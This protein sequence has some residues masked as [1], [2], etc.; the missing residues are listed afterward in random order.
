MIKI[1]Y[2]PPSIYGR[3]V[4]TVLAEKSLD[5]EIVPMSFKEKDHLKPEYLRL[6]PNGEIPTIDD[7]GRIIYESTAVIE[8]LDEEY[9]EP[10]LMPAEPFERAQAR[11]IE[12]FCDLHL[13]RGIVACIRKRRLENLD[14]GEAEITVLRDGLDRIE[15]YL[16]GKKFLAG[17][18]FS[19]ADCA[20]M[21]VPP[22]LE[23]L[24][25]G[26]LLDR[27]ASFKTYVDAL[28]S[29]ASYRNASLLKL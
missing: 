7:D 12:E 6:N 8:Y 22:S 26:G 10:P 13:Y 29:R 24:G 28:K 20:F 14:P 23:G 27:S 21:V 18:A 4:L 1:Y 19:L 11:M 16:A 25:L 2:A 17:D 3:K 9:P 5:Y 15:S